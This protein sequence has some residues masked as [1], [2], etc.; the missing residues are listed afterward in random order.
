MK[1]IAEILSNTNIADPRDTFTYQGAFANP[2]HEEQT[3]EVINQLF[4]KLTSIFPAFKQA[5]PSDTEFENAK[6]MWRRAFV[7]AKIRDVEIIKKGLDALLLQDSPFIPSPGQ[8]IALCKEPAK[9]IKPTTN[10]MD[11]N[12]LENWDAK[13][14]EEKNRNQ[15]VREIEMAKIRKILDMKDPETTSQIQGT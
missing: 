5:W 7:L 1:I 6:G 14:N 4:E 10:T 3:A 8:F 13:S 9:A 12:L 2:V 15:S 11:W